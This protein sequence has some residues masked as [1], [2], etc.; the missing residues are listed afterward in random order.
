MPKH[1]YTTSELVNIYNSDQPVSELVES[2]GISRNS[3]YGARNSLNDYLLRNK[4]IAVNTTRAYRKAIEI[5]RTQIQN[6]TENITANILFSGTSPR[7]KAETNNHFVKLD[8]LFFEFN[9]R[10]KNLIEEA[11]VT[12][13]KQRTNNFNEN[14]HEKEKRIEYLEQQYEKCLY[15]IEEL[16]KKNKKLTELLNESKTESFSIKLKKD[17]ESI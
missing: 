9:S 11:V 4:S 1:F 13:V 14:F 5:L 15:D 10:F 8:D 6:R 12:E 17:L 2:L 16:R 7:P 3:I